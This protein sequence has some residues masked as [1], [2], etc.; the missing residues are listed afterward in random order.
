MPGISGGQG[1]VQFAELGLEREL[2][3]KAAGLRTHMLAGVVDVV[4]VVSGRPP[5][6][7]LA[8]DL[9]ELDGVLAVSSIDPNADD[10]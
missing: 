9:E 2:K 8:A 5:P 7:L 1:L 4:I 10:G 6:P 3:Q